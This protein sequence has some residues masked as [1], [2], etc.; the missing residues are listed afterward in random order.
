MRR[1]WTDPKNVEEIINRTQTGFLPI[2]SGLPGFA[3]YSALDVGDGNLVTLS[4][5]DNAARADESVRAAA[6]WVKSSL[7]PL[8]PNGPIVTSGDVRFLVLANS[9]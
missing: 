7:G 2:V 4:G 3:T 5:F 9:T 8:L 1:Y 6:A